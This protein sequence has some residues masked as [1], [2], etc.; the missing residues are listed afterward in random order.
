MRRLDSLEETW[1]KISIARFTVRTLATELE[2]NTYSIFPYFSVTVF[3][4][5]LFTVSTCMMRDWVKSKPWLGLMGVLSSVLGSLA[6]FGLVCY[7]GVEFIG[8]NMAAPFLMLGEFPFQ[9]LEV[10][11]DEVIM[12]STEAEGG[13]M[14]LGHRGPQVCRPLFLNLEIPLR[15]SL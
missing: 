3:L 8:I 7:C 15:D 14:C 13:H 5:I 10:G 6:A 12:R 2:R 11:K 1:T 4:M 9:I